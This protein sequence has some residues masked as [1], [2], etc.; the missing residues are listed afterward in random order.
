MKFNKIFCLILAGGFCA[1]DVFSDPKLTL[2]GYGWVQ[3]GRI[4]H[5]G[6]TLDYNYS[7]NWMQ[8]AATQITA[9]M[10]FSDN[11]EGYLGIGGGQE[12]LMQGNAT[13]ARLVHIRFAT[14]ITQASFKWHSRDKEDPDLALTV[15]HFPYIYN[16]DVKNLGL[17]LLRG[18]VYPNALVSGFEAKETLPIANFLGTQFHARTGPITHDVLFTSETEF[19]PLFD[20]SLAYIAKH[21]VSE[22]F[23]YGAGVNFYHLLPVYDRIT[24]PRSDKIFNFEDSATA[25]DLK[26][27]I[28]R[29]FFYVDPVSKDTTW[30]SHQG[31]KL[32]GFFGLDIKKLFDFP[33]FGANDLIL[34]SEVGLIGVKNYE[35][36]YSNRMHRMPMMVGLNLPTWGLLD[37]LSLEVEY[38]KNPYKNDVNELQTLLSPLPTSNRTTHIEKVTLDSGYVLANGDTL[39]AVRNVVKANGSVREDIAWGDP[40]DYTGLHKDDWKWS[41]HA[42]KTI[43]GHIRFSGQV[44]NDHFRPAGID[45]EFGLSPTY[46]T[47][48]STLKDWY[49]MSKIT[50][51]F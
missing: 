34:Y 16:T 44:A 11:L 21:K 50:Y 39:R 13:S 8:S 1:A 35:G 22:S 10:S 25:A 47:A 18:P 17:Y 29:N 36:I 4:M 26:S 38:F 5:T 15:G 19:R 37:N 45:S 6:D 2:H 28:E 31:T 49:W 20:F 30:F 33:G 9:N 46:F 51:F 24:N 7:K 14:Y 23:N 40:Y 27:P 12:H 3:A 41:L 43:L 32:T 48:F 42:S